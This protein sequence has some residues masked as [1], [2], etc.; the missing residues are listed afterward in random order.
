MFST[1]D[2]CRAAVIR[3][4][5]DDGAVLTDPNDFDQFIRDAA[6]RLS[7]NE[8][9]SVVVDIAGDGDEYDLLLEA[10]FDDDFSTIKQVEYPAG[11]REKSLVDRLD[12][13]R[14][15]TPTGTYLR[16]LRDVPAVGETVRITFTALHSI[17]GVSTTI[18][19]VRQDAVKLLATALCCE[20]IASHY[21]NSSESTFNADS[22]NHESKAK[23]F[24]ARAKRY[25]DL[26]NDALPRP[27]NDVA[28]ASGDVAIGTEAGHLTHP[29]R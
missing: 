10:P 23:Q 14:Y 5:Q 24:A 25:Y 20:A 8:P 13:E 9:R 16:L 6:L 29:V 4:V 3:M 28:P 2:E 18:P 11:R 26:A 22:V 15:P 21:S 12:W 19:E 7:R 17:D 1:I 27:Q